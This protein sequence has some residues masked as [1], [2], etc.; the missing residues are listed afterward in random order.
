MLSR[1]PASPAVPAG[2]PSRHRPRACSGDLST[3]RGVS[4]QSLNLTLG[5]RLGVRPLDSSKLTR[6]ESSTVAASGDDEGV[7]CS[8]A[9]GGTTAA[10]GGTVDGGA[11][12][13][14]SGACAAGTGCPIEEGCVGSG[15]QGDEPH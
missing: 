11:E 9:R 3:S 2:S 1:A 14:G 6:L 4:S 7:P 8:R 5:L 15:A 12:V 10:D 13:A